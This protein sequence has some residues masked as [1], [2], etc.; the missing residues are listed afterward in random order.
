M[1]K[2]RK[3]KFKPK[4]KGKKHNPKRARLIVRNLPFSV[5]IHISYH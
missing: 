2:E 1:T 3:T 5:R 4:D